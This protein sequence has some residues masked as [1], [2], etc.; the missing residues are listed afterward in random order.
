VIGMI[1]VAHVEPE[2]IRPGAHQPREHLRRTAGRANGGEN[3][4]LASARVDPW[5]L[6]SCHFW[7]SLVGRA[8]G[9]GAFQ[10]K[11]KPR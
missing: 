9:T 10:L 2:R 8:Y 11:E 3:L 6:A 7:L 4:D 5:L 1:A